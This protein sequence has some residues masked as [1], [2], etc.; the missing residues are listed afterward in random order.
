MWESD[1][2]VDGGTRAVD[3]VRRSLRQFRE[4]I[5]G[6]VFVG[7][8][9][10]FKISGDPDV[11]LDAFAYQTPG[12]VEIVGVGSEARVEPRGVGEDT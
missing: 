10:C 9:N 8:D 5:T 11:A 3:T 6:V 12:S 1:G 7:V 2:G 4:S